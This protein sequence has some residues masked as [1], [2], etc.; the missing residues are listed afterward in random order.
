MKTSRFNRTPPGYL[1][2]PKHGK[3]PPLSVAKG[4]SPS[5]SDWHLDTAQENIPP[6]V[7]YARAQGTCG[8][9]HTRGANCTLAQDWEMCGHSTKILLP[10]L[11]FPTSLPSPI[12]MAS[13]ARAPAAALCF[14]PLLA[15]TNPRA[16][17]QL[18]GNAGGPLARILLHLPAL[19]GKCC[20]L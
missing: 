1:H 15:L 12:P 13:T 2:I 20:C 14:H 16:K 3:A 10:R 19:Q 18:G 11:S 4:M 7:I 5:S 8:D 9:T 17:E 6:A